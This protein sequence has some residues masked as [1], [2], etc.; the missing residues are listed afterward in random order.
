MELTILEV[1]GNAWSK[2]WIHGG[3][4][5]HKSARVISRSPRQKAL[6]E[7]RLRQADV[8]KEAEAKYQ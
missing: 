6:S 7:Q 3:A 2:S 8:K 5:A 4:E 1:L